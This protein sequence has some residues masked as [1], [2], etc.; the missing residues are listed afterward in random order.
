MNSGATGVDYEGG[1]K[2]KD[3][4]TDDSKSVRNEQEEGKDPTKYGTG[5]DHKTPVRRIAKEG[6]GSQGDDDRI[7]PR[8]REEDYRIPEDD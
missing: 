5:M 1:I 8:V 7:K 2:V 3:K 4:I 6:K